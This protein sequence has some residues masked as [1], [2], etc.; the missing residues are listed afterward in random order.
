MFKIGHIFGAFILLAANA[1]IL[2]DG[3]FMETVFVFEMTRHGARS[4]FMNNPD[5][6]IDFFG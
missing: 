2:D 6:D 3:D 4:H 5:V 1:K